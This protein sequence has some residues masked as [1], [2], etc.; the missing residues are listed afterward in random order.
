MRYDLTPVR[1]AIIR[2]LQEFP[3][4]HRR[5][6]IQLQRLRFDSW[7]GAVGERIWHGYDYGVG[8]SCSSE[9]IPGLGTSIGRVCIAIKKKI[10]SMDS[11]C[12]WECKLVQLPRRSVWRFLK[13][14]NIKLPMIQQSHFWSSIQRKP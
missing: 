10:T 14:L 2:S 7:P 4:W 6:R 5:L 13:K 11:K 3:L 12:W 8:H 1:M 9:S